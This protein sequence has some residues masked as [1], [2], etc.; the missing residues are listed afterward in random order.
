MGSHAAGYSFFLKDGRLGFDYN[1][2]GNHTVLTGDRDVPLGRSTVGVRFRREGE[3][4]GTFT[5]VVGDEPVAEASIP[6][7]VN[8]FGSMGLDV[9]RD[10][11]SPV[12]EEYDGAFPFTGTLHE[13]RYDIVSRRPSPAEAST[14]E[15]A[16]FGTQ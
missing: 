15:K 3:G 16:G 11:L 4:A 8:I 1:D 10:G 9:G 5:L 12:S 14:D 6:R 13:V 7:R 2:F